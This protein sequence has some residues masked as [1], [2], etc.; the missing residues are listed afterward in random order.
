[1]MLGCG[2][3]NL[4]KYRVLLCDEVNAGHALLEL[5]VNIRVLH[6]VMQD[7]ASAIESRL[8][9]RALRDKV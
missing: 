2:S 4:S 5:C 8:L 9:S 3:D 7:L 6:K 1:M